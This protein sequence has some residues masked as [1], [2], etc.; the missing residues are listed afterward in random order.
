MKRA[1]RSLGIIREIKGIAKVPTKTLLQIFDSLV[2]SIFNYAS[3]VWQI[4]NPSALDKLNEV[5]RAGLAMCLDLPLQSSLETLQV[6]SGT[7]P[8]DLR[9]EEMAIRELAKINSFSNNIPIKKKFESWKCEEQPEFCISPLGKMFQQAED[10]KKTENIDIDDIEPQYD[11]QGLV[12]VIHP[13]DYWRNIGSSKSRSVQQIEEGKRI[14]LDQLN[15]LRPHS[16]AAFTDGSC[17]GNPGPCG[18]GA[19]IYFNNQTDKLKRP[20]SRR[21]SILLAE[22]IAIKL[23]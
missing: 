10:M 9:R 8:L 14:I 12:S 21:G 15:N 13:P 19:I 1:K 4:G 22:L 3:S 11:F 7:L 20:V 18:A 5:Q 6:A 23:Y 2:C 16:I 17:N